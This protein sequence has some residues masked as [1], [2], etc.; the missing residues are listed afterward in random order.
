MALGRDGKAHNRSIIADVETFKQGQEITLIL[1]LLNDSEMR[2]LGVNVKDYKDVCE[3]QGIIFYQ[4]PIIEMAP[5]DDLQAFKTEVI[6][7]IIEHLL[8]DAGGNVLVHCRG[9]VGRAGLV[10]CCVL[11]TLCE[12]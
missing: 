10:A 11:A 6:D 3:K 12:F 5:P 9:G 1:C 7:I 2:H 4:H 8:K